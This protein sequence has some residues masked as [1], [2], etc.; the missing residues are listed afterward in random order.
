[1]VAC[2]EVDGVMGTPDIIDDLFIV[3]YLVRERTGIDFLAN[4]VLIGSMNRGGLAGAAFEMDDT[5]TAYTV[6]GIV[7]RRLD[8]AKLMVRLDINSYDSAQTLTYAAEAVRECHEYGVPIFVESLPGTFENNKWTAAKDAE[9]LIKIVGVASA[10]GDS[11]VLTWLK[12]P[13]CEG[14]ERVAR[15]TTCPILMLG[16]ESRG[17]PT[18]TMEEFEKGMRAGGNVRGALV[19]RN[20]LFPGNDDPAAVAQAIVAIV[21]QQATTLEAVR[22]LSSLR[23]QQMDALTKRRR[24]RRSKSR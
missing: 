23:G 2:S 15:A 1:V 12:L 11:T 13:Y 10:L 18:F 17:D 6:Q 9:A 5:M 7:D 14:Y 24:G 8:A 4:R 21:H 3:N 19:G 16:G 20:V 22:L